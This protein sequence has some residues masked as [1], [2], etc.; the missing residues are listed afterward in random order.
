M[1]SLAGPSLL[2][3]GLELV[4]RQIGP[5]AQRAARILRWS[6][7]S[8]SVPFSPAL[9]HDDPS[10]RALYEPYPSTPPDRSI[11]ESE[12]SSYTHSPVTRFRA[13]R[14]ER[15][16]RPIT[17]SSQL[18]HI[19]RSNALLIGY[20]ERNDYAGATSLRRDLDALHTPITEDAIYARVAQHLLKNP[21]QSDPHAFLRWCELVPEALHPWSKN[22]SIPVA[23]TEILG[24]LLRQPEDIEALCRFSTVAARKG[25]S[26]WVTIPAI[27]HVTRYSTPDVASKLLGD[28]ANAASESAIRTQSSSIPPRVMRSWNSTFI[29]GLCLSGRIDPAHESLL[30]LHSDRRTV[31]PNAYRIVAEELELLGRSAEAQ[32]LRTLCEDAGYARPHFATRSFVS[33]KA[34]S[35]PRLPIARQ[36]LWIKAR[37]GTGRNISATDLASFMKSYLSTGHYRALSLLRNRLVRLSRNARWKFSLGLWATAEMQLY[38]SK[39]QHAE[40]LQV[41]RSVFLPAGIPNQLLHEVGVSQFPEKISSEDAFTP[42]WPPSE[43]VAS[44]AWS[45]ATLATS[46]DDPRVLE[47]CYS[48]FVQACNPAS[49]NL[50]QLPPAMLPDATA[51]Q[52]WIGAFARRSGPEGVIKVMKD[53]RELKVA[54]TIMTWNALAKAYVSNSEWEVAKSILMKMEA[55]RDSSAVEIPPSPTKERV[56]NRLGPVADW[57][58]PPADSS[59]YY[60]LLRELYMTKQVTAGRELKDMLVRSGYRSGDMRL[61]SF[62]RGIDSDPRS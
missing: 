5:S 1:A 34:G 57:G 58:F 41:F 38:R 29:R 59:T 51:F 17:L 11:F 46:H 50:F 43:A 18:P 13:L 40:V 23:M 44:A 21:D 8:V 2:P 10:L 28:I 19:A 39:G 62:L 6:Y 7:S 47:H 49:N 56:R 45:A 52:P 12:D 31:G 37:I 55:S 3:L 48:L 16:R 15:I 27:S 60:V 33:Q 53:M 32:H 26:V 9:P 24:T 25:M 35:M 20:V 4:N 42:L 30:A 36:L 22:I 14:R 61:E 54:P